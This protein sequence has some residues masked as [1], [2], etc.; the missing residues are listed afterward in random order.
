MFKTLSEFSNI[1]ITGPQRS[2]TRIT[3][4]II[5]NDTEKTYID[6]KDINFHDYRLLKWYLNQ[7]NIVIQCPGLCHLIHHI[8]HESTLTIIVRRPIE[9]IINSEIRC[10]NLEAEKHELLKYGY[11]NGIIS[12]IKYEF[13]DNVQK[14]ILGNSAR[15]INYHD[16]EKHPLFINNRENFNWNQTQ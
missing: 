11:T 3:A 13:W 5:S 2:G 4:K 12:R 8:E 15:E 16:L 1:I 10:W 9:E 6:E 14:S 7:N